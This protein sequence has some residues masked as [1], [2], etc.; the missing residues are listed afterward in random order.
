[1]QYKG[2]RLRHELKFL[3]T[4]PERD[5]LLSTI[6]AVMPLDPHSKDG[7]YLIR[8]LYFDDMY[9]GAYVDKQAGILRRRKHRIRIYNCSDSHISF[10]IKDKFDNYISKI[11]AKITLDECRKII[12]GD[13][14]FMIDSPKQAL[15]AGFIDA[16]TKLLHPSVVVDYYRTA[17]VGQEG[18]VRITF[19][20]DLRSGLGSTDIF[21]PDLVTVAAM[22]PGWLILEV[23]YDDYLPDTVRA[24]LAPINA[25]QSSQSK[26]TLCRSAQNTFYGKECN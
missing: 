7:G 25:R 19:D 13:Y 20:S 26:Y 10:E 5:M 21:N 14:G 12:A 6:G 18:N 11:S 9:S 24:L 8:S 3:I 15:R 4:E 23:K 17:F 1:M 16:R 2:H 22:E